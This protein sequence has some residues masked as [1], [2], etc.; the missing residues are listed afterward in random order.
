MITKTDHMEEVSLEAGDIKKLRRQFLPM[1]I[2]PVAAGAI[3]YFIFN[4]VISDF[5]DSF[6]EGGVFVYIFILFGLFFFGIIAYIIWSYAADLKKGIKQRITGVVTDKNLYI[7]RTTSTGAG[8]RN[9]SSTKTTKYYYVFID[10]IKYTMDYRSYNNVTVGDTIR[11]DRAP[12]SGLTLDIQ[13]LEDAE[14]P[15]IIEAKAIDLSYLQTKIEPVELTAEDLRAMKRSMLTSM[16][17][18][19]AW[20]VPSLLIIFSLVSAGLSGLLIFL[21]PIVIIAGVQFYKIIRYFLNYQRNKSN[22]M[23]HGETAIV[24]DKVTVT[25]NRASERYQVNT[26]IGGISVNKSA[27]DVLNNN[28]RVIIWRPAFGRNKLSVVTM[29]KNEYYLS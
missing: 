1:L 16:R 15:Q 3:F 20:M 19:F 13:I 23:K 24:T 21:F 10:N 11:Y 4:F 8:R 7:K 28:D 14:T 29:D 17:R 12:K 26:S 27:Y 6:S 18:K 5:G 22:G 2:F 9:G 25:S